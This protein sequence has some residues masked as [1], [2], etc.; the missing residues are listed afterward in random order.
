MKSGVNFTFKISTINIPEKGQ[1]RFQSLLF[2]YLF[3]AKIKIL[4]SIANIFLT[5]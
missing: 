5:S 3:L 2:S 1:K 4:Q